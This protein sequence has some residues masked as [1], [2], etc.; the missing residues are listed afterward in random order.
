MNIKPGLFTLS[1]Y[2]NIILKSIIFPIYLG[3]IKYVDKENIISNTMFII[4]SIISLYILINLFIIRKISGSLLLSFIYVILI[5]TI[6]YENRFEFK[7]YSENERNITIL[8]II[9]S[10]LCIINFILLVL[11]VGAAF[12]RGS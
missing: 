12:R 3:K 5:I 2:L 11:K 9:S 6:F 1:L 10:I 7:N 4:I 8:M